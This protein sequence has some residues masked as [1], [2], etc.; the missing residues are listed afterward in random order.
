M[1]GQNRSNDDVPLLH[2]FILSGPLAGCSEAQKKTIDLPE[3]VPL[4][5]MSVDNRLAQRDHD[6]FLGD[7][8]C[9]RDRGMETQNLTNHVVEV[10]HSIQLVHGRGVRVKGAR[11][12]AQ[13]SA[14]HWVTCK[15]VERP[16][17]T[18]ATDYM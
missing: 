2:P 12:R 8:I 1:D 18:S 6:I 4:D 15:S 9:V 11:L 10:R 17:G 14:S 13:F 7:P 3:F 5:P 16:N